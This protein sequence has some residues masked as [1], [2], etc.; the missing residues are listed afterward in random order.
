MSLSNDPGHYFQTTSALEET[1][2]KA[3]KSKNTKGNPTKLPSKILAVIAD[4][5]D[6]HHVYVAEA[7]GSVK[8]INIETSKV[9]AT[10]SGPTAP[11]TSIAVSPK[12]GTLFAACWD[13]S[14]WSWSL[15]SRKVSTRFQGHS[16]FVKAIISFTLNGKEVLVSAS[17]DASII[18]WDVAAGKKLHILKGHTR[19]ILALALDPVDY[20]PGKDTITVFSAGS[21]REIRR[22]QIASS[23]AREIQPSPI[24]AHETS[25][26]A[27]H[28]DVDG[29]LW[30]ASADKTAKCLSRG[31]D[32]EEDSKFEHP[33]FVRDVVID[34]AGGWIVT[35][36]RD[37]EIRVWERASGR[38][39]H[40]FNGHFEEVTGLLLMGQ[41]LISV[42]IDATVRQ[43][44]LKPQELA[45]SIEEAE[46]ERL[47]EETAKEPE[48]KESLMTVEEEAEL[49]ELLE[50]SD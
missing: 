32:W 14:I 36:C 34:E 10:F 23:S 49:A 13:K 20:E 1:A 2:R 37:E 31:R 19:G 6:E 18:V 22:W 35:A 4:P 33:D 39:H 11:L 29:D 9:V 43:W 25:I 41:R 30:T 12:S 5:Q 28:F 16:D 27:L 17:Q 3:A 45:K 7:A 38:L 47:G 26:D 50:D 46:K 24:I 21:D 15:S 48:R 8:H 40:T 44:N 42:S